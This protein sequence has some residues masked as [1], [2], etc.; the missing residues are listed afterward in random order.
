LKLK[1]EA[2]QKQV[3]AKQIAYNVPCPF[4]LPV[5]ARIIAKFKDELKTEP[6]G[7]GQ[8]YAGIIAEPPKNTN[9][10]RY[11]V[12]FDDGYAQYVDSKEVLMVYESSKEVW[13]DVHPDSSEFIRN[14]VQKYP[15]RPMVRLSVGQMLTTEWNGNWWV[16]RVMEVDGSLAKLK[17]ENDERIEWMYRGSTRLS[18][19]FE[20]QSRQK[21]KL[22]AR[23]HVSTVTR[24][25][26]IKVIISVFQ[27]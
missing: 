4:M 5:G 9:S 20:K 10:F 8:Y 12:F 18:P 23:R 21:T 3:T 25:C 16:A 15:E 2:T 19:L 13:S 14:Y 6:I 27:F 26:C 11:L 17:F 1:N 7:N 24:V 22:T